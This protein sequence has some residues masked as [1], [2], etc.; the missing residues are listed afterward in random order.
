MLLETVQHGEY[1][2]DRS[3]VLTWHGC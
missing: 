2:K 3:E 1:G